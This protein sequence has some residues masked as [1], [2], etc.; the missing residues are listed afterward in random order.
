MFNTDTY[1]N[2]V[3]PDGMA[4]HEYLI[5]IYIAFQLVNNLKTLF[6]KNGRVQ[7]QIYM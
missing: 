1:A 7:S 5:R 2:N 3:D 4:H 6:E